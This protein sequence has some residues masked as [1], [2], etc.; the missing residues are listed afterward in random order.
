MIEMLTP[1]RERYRALRADEA[2]LEGVL[3]RGADRASAIAA[4]T[5]ADVRRAMGVGP[6]V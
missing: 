1:V 3:G 6:V 4:D 5:L 2:H